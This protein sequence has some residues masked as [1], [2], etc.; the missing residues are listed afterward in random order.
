MSPVRS[1]KRRV[2]RVILV[3]AGPGDPGLLTIKACEAISRADVIMHDY[4]IHPGTLKFA[5]PYAWI[6]HVGKRSPGAGRRVMRSSQKQIERLM[7]KHA[8]AGRTVVRLKGGDP[9]LFGRGGEECQALAK[10]GINVEVIPGVTSALAV[11]AAAGIPLTHRDFSSSVTIVTGHRAPGA[12]NRASAGAGRSAR[13]IDWG[14]VARA[15]QTIVVLMGAGKAGM[16]ARELMRAGLAKS[17]PI[18]AVRWGTW[19]QQKVFT[20]TLATVGVK[21]R[22]LDRPAVLVI[23]KVVSLRRH[24]PHQR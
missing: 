16:I 20:A 21:F 24:I 1:V 3:G 10:A 12:R 14:A 8:R 5:R 13:D 19:P 6:M 4:L 2:G 15:G 18:A 17:T 23:G 22:G 7:I 9:F 11:P